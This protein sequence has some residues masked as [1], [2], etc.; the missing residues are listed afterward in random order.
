MRAM[1]WKL[2]SLVVAL[3]CFQSAMPAVLAYAESPRVPAAVAHIE[4][5]T[6][7]SCVPVHPEHCTICR[8]LV[9]AAPLREA[10]PIAVASDPRGVALRQRV[11]PTVVGAN[12]HQHQSRAPPSA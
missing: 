3:A 9:D 8:A 4:D 6:Q 2:R 12:A 7:R 5:E 11:V 1:S 10:P